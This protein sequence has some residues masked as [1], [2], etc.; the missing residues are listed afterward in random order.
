VL[1]DE[2]TPEQEAQGALEVVF[3]NGALMRDEKF[4]DIRA[5]LGVTTVTF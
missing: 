5:R 1:Y 4:S 3:E 2:Q